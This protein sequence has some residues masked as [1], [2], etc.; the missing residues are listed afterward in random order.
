MEGADVTRK[1]IISTLKSKY[2]KFG[3][4][5]MTMVC[6]PGDYGVSLLPEAERKLIDEFGYHAGLMER[7]RRSEGNRKKKNRLYVRLD[8]SLFE[9]VNEV[10]QR[11]AFASMQDMIE[12]AL[13]EFINRRR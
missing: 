7:R 8:D 1:Q 3:K 11:S 12:A 9:Q 10:Y 6:N 4:A 5:T 13:V 2:K